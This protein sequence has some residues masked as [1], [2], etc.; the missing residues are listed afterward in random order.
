LL[1]RARGSIISRSDPMDMDDEI[2]GVQETVKG[3]IVTRFGDMK[4]T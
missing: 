1:R 4:K 3:E 2:G